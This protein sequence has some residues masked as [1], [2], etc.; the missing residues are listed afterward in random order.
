MFDSLKV[1]TFRDFEWLVVDDGST[2]GTR[3]LVAGWSKDPN[4]DFPIRYQRQENAHKKTAHNRAVNEARGE[5]VLV[6]DSDDRCVPNALEQ[7]WHHWNAIPPSQRDRFVGVCGLCMDETGRIVGDRF[8][9]GSFVDSDSLEIKYRYRVSGEKWGVMRTDVLKA[10]PFRED[11]PGLVPEGTVWNAI[12]QRYKTRFFNE[13]L[14]IYT[15]DVP[16]LIARQGDVI[17][18]AENAPGALYAKKKTLDD[19]IEYFRHAPVAFFLEAA[20]LTRFWLHTP[21]QW[22]MRLGYWPDST[23]GKLLVVLSSPL[24]VLMWF[25]DQRRAGRP[26]FVKGDA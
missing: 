7:F 20:R 3:Q 23:K 1:Q 10:F 19:D 12:A 22:K 6:F 24:G 2:D 9:G 14:R 13:A 26:L 4:V 15:Q 16:G 18:A 25:R 21:S 17:D 11:I 5:L 8:P